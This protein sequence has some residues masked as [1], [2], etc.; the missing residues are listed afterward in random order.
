MA[1]TQRDPTNITP[2]DNAQETERLLKLAE[3]LEERCQ[4]MERSIR[5]RRMVLATIGFI[6]MGSTINSLSTNTFA[7]V[8]MESWKLV[9]SIILGVGYG[10]AMLFFVEQSMQ[11]RK[12]AL[13]RD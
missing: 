11:R 10:V 2:P 9:A 12:R 7:A 3:D 1:M 5:R 8:Q 4:T 6:C 13:E